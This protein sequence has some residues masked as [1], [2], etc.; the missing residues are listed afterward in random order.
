MNNTETRQRLLTLEQVAERYS[1]SL[2]TLQ[3]WEAERKVPNSDAL[4][5][6]FN[7]IEA[8][9]CFEGMEHKLH[10][11]VAWHDGAIWYDLGNWKAVKVTKEGWEIVDEPLHTQATP[12]PLTRGIFFLIRL[13]FRAFLDRC[14]ESREWIC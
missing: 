5:S 9:A 11:R 12:T 2:K 3:R 13:T 10:N 1:L 14:L 8:K 4:H 7:V 6:A